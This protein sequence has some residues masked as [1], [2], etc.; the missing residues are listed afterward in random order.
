MDSKGIT[1]VY[2][3]RLN[4]IGGYM[5]EGIHIV[6]SRL[7]HEPKTK[8]TITREGIKEEIKLDDFL[9]AMKAEINLQELADKLKS[10][11]GSIALTFSAEKFAQKVDSAMK[12]SE[13]FFENQIDS[14]VER[15]IEGL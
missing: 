8:I 4:S 9:K 6:K 10:E 11:I 7:W 1:D 3:H 2:I 12:Q 13:K 5:K 15:V 14:A